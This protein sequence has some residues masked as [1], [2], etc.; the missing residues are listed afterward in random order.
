MKIKF[1]FN[2]QIKIKIVFCLNETKDFI[3]NN[4]V[5]DKRTNTL[6]QIKI[7]TEMV[8]IFQE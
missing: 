7:F 4:C 2:Q 6:A 8:Y 5:L 1:N 3:V